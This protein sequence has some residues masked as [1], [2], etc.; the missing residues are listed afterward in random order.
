MNEVGLFSF[1]PREQQ[2]NCET[3]VRRESLV[4]PYFTL[5]DYFD[6]YYYYFPWLLSISSL[7]LSVCYRA[8]PFSLLSLFPFVFALRL[9]SSSEY[10]PVPG[11]RRRSMHRRRNEMTSITNEVFSLS[12]RAVPHVGRSSF[13]QSTNSQEL[14]RRNHHVPRTSADASGVT[15]DLQR[16]ETGGEHRK[17]SVHR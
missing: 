1:I 7:S 4:L 5:A 10:F 6:Y 3:P 11:L 8:I 13:L 16:D 2:H 15:T 17:G 14:P 9:L 12:H